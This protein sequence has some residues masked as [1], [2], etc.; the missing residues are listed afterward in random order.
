MVSEPRRQ[1][2]GGAQ[3]LYLHGFG[4]SQQ[5]DKAEFFRRRF[6]AEG[7][8]FVSFDF[9]GHGLSGGSIRD[10]TLSRCLRDAA[11]V[12][13]ALVGDDGRAT[14][15]A[16]SSMGGL[17]GLW[18]ATEADAAAGAFIAPALGLEQ[19]FGEL[20]GVEGMRRWKESGVLPITNELGTF[21]L[22]W[23]FVEDLRGRP[24]EDL[25]RR[26]R[27]PTII[28]QGRLDD[29]VPWQT[30]ER[31]AEATKQTT[32]LRLFAQ[33]DH[34]LLA[35]KESVWAEIRSFLGELGLTPR[36]TRSGVPAY[37]GRL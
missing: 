8:R 36:E 12:H 35:H 24:T 20:I 26:H 16:G 22:G 33:G 14:V 11:R 4:S 2:E 9:Q 19:S 18:H 23:E 17:V 37:E 29:R 15:I 27:L 25:H 30:V 21:E 6:T 32:R 3:V 10:L 7:L 31:F 1:A 13:R 34:R 5:G 28:F